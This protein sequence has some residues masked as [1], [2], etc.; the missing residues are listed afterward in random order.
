MLCFS[1]DDP[2]DNL[3]MATIDSRWIYGSTVCS[4][5][6]LSGFPVALIRGSFYARRV[7]ISLFSFYDLPLL[8]L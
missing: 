5:A 3:F 6:Y 8:D 4:H 1:A 7:Y 2:S